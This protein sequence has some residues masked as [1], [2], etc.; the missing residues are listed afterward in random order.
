MK[1]FYILL[2]VLVANIFAQTNTAFDSFLLSEQVKP[3]SVSFLV[4]NVC[5]NKYIVNYKTD[6]LMVP[7]SVQ[8]L[9]T[10]SAALNILTEDFKFVTKINLLGEIIENRFIGVI[11]VVASGDPT[12]NETLIEEIYDFL[13]AKNINSIE[14]YITV[15]ENVFD[16]AFPQTWL[17]EDIANYYGSPAYS[18]NYLKNTYKLTFTQTAEGL[19]PKIKSI[20]PYMRKLNFENNLVSG[21]EKSGDHAYILGLPFSN[22]RQIVGTI[23]AGTGTFSIKGAINNPAQIFKNDLIKKFQKENFKFI[24]NKDVKKAKVIE[25]LIH[26]SNELTKII[27]TTNKKSINLYAEAL[28][29][30]I[31]YKKYGFGTTEN[32]IKA[33]KKYYNDESLI[34]YDGSGLS[35][36][37]LITANFVNKIL[38][39]NKENKVFK[40]SLGISGV[41]GTMKYFKSDKTRGK[42]YAKSGSADNILNFAGYFKNSKGEEFTFVIFINNYLGDRKFLRKE[43]V[44]LMEYFL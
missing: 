37:D 35:R 38:L 17:V 16:N 24:Y 18:F 41:S 39:T 6:K 25:T 10:T 4:Y 26:E 42:I 34:I 13:S 23:P 14:G 43:I 20:S 22:E 40:N 28:L 12:L 36:K 8:K 15:K 1:Y 9:V 32:G 33:L 2:N 30:M 21:S 5:Q 44:K 19:N 27:N 29:K 3:A 7:A 31:A 11:E